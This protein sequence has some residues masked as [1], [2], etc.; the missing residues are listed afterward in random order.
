[1]E[2]K[3]SLGTKVLFVSPID[4]NYVALGIVMK[5]RYLMDMGQQYYIQWMDDSCNWYSVVEVDKYV[6]DLMKEL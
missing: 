1:M 4:D 5:A 3:Y 2:F 6:Q